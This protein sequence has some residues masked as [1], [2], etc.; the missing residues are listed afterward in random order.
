MRREVV[1]MAMGFVGC[2]CAAAELPRVTLQAGDRLQGFVVR[3]VEELPDIR[4]RFV[5]MTYEK[6]GAEVAWL[7]RA[8]E[9]KTFGVSFRTLPTDDTGVVTLRG[10]NTASR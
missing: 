7:D 5:R 4:A 8:D 2:A 3:T 9:N 6:N 1:L 10:W